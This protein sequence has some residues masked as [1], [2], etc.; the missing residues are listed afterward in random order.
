M[1]NE[2][3]Y[4]TIYIGGTDFGFLTFYNSYFHLPMKYE[5]KS[6]AIYFNFESIFKKL[7]TLRIL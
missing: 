6:F 2:E 7:K 1:N 5:L 3:N 4:R